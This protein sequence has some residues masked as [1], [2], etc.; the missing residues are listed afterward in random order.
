[1]AGKKIAGRHGASA[2]R[3]DFGDGK[4]VTSRYYVQTI[5]V[6]FEHSTRFPT[7]ARQDRRTMQNKTAVPMIGDR[8]RPGVEASN[9]VV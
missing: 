9:H 2:F 7:N 1:M 8:M 5:S 4:K 3:L 6:R